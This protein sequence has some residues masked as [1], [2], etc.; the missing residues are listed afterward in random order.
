MQEVLADLLKCSGIRL[1]ILH[2][3]HKAILNAH[4]DEF[5]LQEDELLIVFKLLFLSLLCG[6][7]LLL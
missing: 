4:I 7:D 3:S 5:I 2:R 6:S 1:C